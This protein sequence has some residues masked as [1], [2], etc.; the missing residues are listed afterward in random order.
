MGLFKLKKMKRIKALN[1]QEFEQSCSDGTVYGQYLGL[2][3][4]LE[5]GEETEYREHPKDDPK[6]DYRKFNNC[7]IEY[8][9]TLQELEEGNPKATDDKNIVILYW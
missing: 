5:L 8:A 2:M 1:K 4:Y 3:V 7:Y 6:T 9:E